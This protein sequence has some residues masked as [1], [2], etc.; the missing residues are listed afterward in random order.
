VL[1][2]LLLLL[3]L[4]AISLDCVAITG[5]GSAAVAVVA[6]VADSNDG[7]AVVLDC[8][9]PIALLVMQVSRFNRVSSLFLS[10]SLPLSGKKF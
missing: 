10:P 1:L 2:V 8:V 5:D 4:V 6:V 7:T 9:A 3:H